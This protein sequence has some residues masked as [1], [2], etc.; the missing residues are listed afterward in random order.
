MLKKFYYT[1]KQLILITVFLIC[2]GTIMLY[3]ASS[4]YAIQKF[5]SHTYFLNKHLFRVILG[6]F[7]MIAV[8]LFDYRNLKYLDPYILLFSFLLIL[9]THLLSTGKTARWLIIGGKN[10]F[11]TSDI[12]R[13]SLIIFVAYYLEKSYRYIKDFY[14]GLLPIISTIGIILAGII[15]EPD[16][17]TA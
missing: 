4:H 2:I 11:T 1:D 14:K 6:I 8:S 13:I 15:T 5:N 3:S 17:S 12:A 7:I 9:I 16:L 10:L